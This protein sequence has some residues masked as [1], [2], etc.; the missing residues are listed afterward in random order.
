MSVGEPRVRLERDDERFIL[1]ETDSMEGYC[2][3]S[4]SPS[5]PGKQVSTMASRQFTNNSALSA[6]ALLYS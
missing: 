6:V 2:T 5:S 4:I 3:S 1:D